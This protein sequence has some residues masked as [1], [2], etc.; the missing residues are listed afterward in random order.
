MIVLAGGMP[1]SGST[2]SFNIA[3]LALA[4]RGTVVSAASN[5][6]SDALAAGGQNHVLLKSHLPEH[7][8][9][10]LVQLGAVKSIVT[11]RR[12]EDAILSWMHTFGMPLEDTINAFESWFTIFHELRE[13]SLV[14]RFEDVEERPARTAF[15]LGRSLFGDYSPVE[16]WRASRAFS[17]KRVSKLIRDVE[18]KRRP[19]TDAGFTYYDDETYFHRRHISD[20]SQFTASSE[21]LARIRAAFSAWIDDEGNVRL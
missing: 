8:V 11:V 14:L 9:I 13:C 7:E 3:R 6:L 5:S 18:E 1:R 10:R 19:T 4:R 2:W 17:R 20:R 16:A 21:D 15:R 12:P